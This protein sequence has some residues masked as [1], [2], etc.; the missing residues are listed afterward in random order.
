MR[1]G[2]HAATRGAG[3]R[4]RE[5]PPGRVQEHLL[6]PPPTPVSHRVSSVSSVSAHAPHYRVS[7]PPLECFMLDILDVNPRRPP[8]PTTIADH[9]CRPPVP[10]TQGREQYLSLLLQMHRLCVAHRAQSCLERLQCRSSPFSGTWPAH[11]LGLPVPPAARKLQA[12]SA[13]K[14]P[15]GAARWGGGGGKGGAG[16]GGQPQDA[17]GAARPGRPAPT[18]APAAQA[19]TAGN[20]PPPAAPP[21]SGAPPAPHHRHPSP[22]RTIAAFLRL[23]TGMPCWS[24][25]LEILSQNGCRLPQVVKRHEV[26]VV[27]T[28]GNHPSQRSRPETLPSQR[29][30]QHT[31]FSIGTLGQRV[32]LGELRPKL[33]ISERGSLPRIGCR[34]C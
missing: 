7:C 27:T 2:R 15:K 14:H 6:R 20:T 22:R 9:Q 17:A 3:Q 32:H 29:T 4:V 12:G 25:L 33:C 23:S 21:A 11:R 19:S 8:L 30:D 34:R 10:I 1:V 16:R 31:C 26:R 13:A 5:G 24:S 18:P 28:A